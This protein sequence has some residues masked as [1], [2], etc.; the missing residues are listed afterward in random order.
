MAGNSVGTAYLTLVPKLDDGFAKQAEKSLGQ[1]GARGGKEFEGS[2]SDKLKDGFKKLAGLAIVAKAGQEVGKAFM[3]AFNGYADYEQLAGGVEKIFGEAMSSQIINDANNAYKNLNMSANQYLETINDVGANFKATMGAEKGY[4]T[5]QTGLQA[6]ADYASG[7]GKNI[8]ELKEKFTLITRATSSYQSIA[9]QFSGILPA[10]SE[11]FL[12]QS[13]AAGFLSDKYKK[14]TE[15]PIE[16]YQEAVS[17]MLEKGT[18]D[19]GLAGNTAEETERTL[20]G[21]IAGMKAAWENFLVSLGDP[22]GN[23]DQAMQNL[24]KMVLAAGRNVMDAAGR[25]IENVAANMPAWMQKIGNFLV[26]NSPQIG[27]AIGEII[28]KIASWIIDNMP[29]ILQASVTLFQGI[30]TGLAIASATVTYK[31]AM[32]LSDAAGKVADAAGSM[33]QAAV[34]WIGG[35]VSGI[36][37]RVSSV[38]GAIG[39]M[40]GQVPGKVASFVGEMTQAGAQLIQGM[41]AGLS[42]SAVLEKIR[43]ICSQCVDQIKNFFGIHS[44][45]RVM[46]E[47]FGYVG[48]GMVLGIE[49]SEK[50]VDNAMRNLLGSA[51]SATV[52][53]GIGM[54]SSMVG[55]SN[56]AGANIVG[57]IETLHNDLYAIIKDATPDG[58][59]GRQFGRLVHRYA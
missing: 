2:F 42:P 1:S 20:S 34:A 15:V 59:T 3:T 38:L 5:A 30:V 51:Y 35:I 29:A 37:S 48:D 9:D 40:I 52:D 17:K 28:T 24:A 26:A 36:D 33:I 23:I 16:E 13:Q 18:A 12:K 46:R 50:D 27:T 44:P 25:I 7:T 57:A 31:L 11:Q 8:D 56:A 14:L 41:V 21:S 45:S 55:G 10:T 32:F 58:I 39:S 49:D 22:D 54:N 4:K 6:I 47:L 43:S 19:L 53:Y